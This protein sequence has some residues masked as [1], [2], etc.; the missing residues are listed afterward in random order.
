MRLV[1]VS[2]ECPCQ[3]PLGSVW[4]RQIRTARNVLDAL[5]LQDGKQ[6]DEESLQTFMCET[7]AIVNSRPLAVC[8]ISSPTDAEPLTPN[9]LLTMKSRILLPPPGEFQRADLYLVKRWRRVQYLV[10]QFWFRWRKDFLCT[11]QERPK[12]NKPRRNM[13]VGDIVLIKDDNAPRNCWR[14]ARVDNVYTGN[15][16]LVRKVRIVVA[17][18]DSSLNEHGE[19]VRA[20]SILERPVQKLVLL[21]RSEDA[22]T[23]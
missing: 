5:L 19:R 21:L 1:R 17:D 14:K 12:W 20:T 8:N 16:G 15:D 23:Q 6:L 13:C 22:R 18:S 11:L 2:N 4:E 3:Q 10:D 7:E 9:H